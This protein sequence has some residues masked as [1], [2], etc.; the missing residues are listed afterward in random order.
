MATLKTLQSETRRQEDDA[1]PGP[2]S[3]SA[4]L[5]NTPLQQSNVPLLQKKLFGMEDRV[6]DVTNA[7]R[8]P[9]GH[10]VAIVGMGGIGKTTLAKAVCHNPTIQSQFPIMVWVVV[11]WSLRNLGR[12]RHIKRFIGHCLNVFF[13][14]SKEK[15][16]WRN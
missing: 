2:S 10:I 4:S 1:H 9:N 7:L 14:V 12:R 16:N 3:M 6:A 11:S 8:Q 15:C 13:C 5:P